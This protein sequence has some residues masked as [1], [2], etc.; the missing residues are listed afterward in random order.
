MAFT[1]KA[2]RI[3]LL[4]FDTF[5]ILLKTIRIRFILFSIF[6]FSLYAHVRIVYFSFYLE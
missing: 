2:I 4:H 5:F 3:S 1:K 6:L